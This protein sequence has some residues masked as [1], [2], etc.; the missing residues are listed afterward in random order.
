MERQRRCCV[1]PCQHIS[2]VDHHFFPLIKG[3]AQSLFSFPF[4]FFFILSRNYKKTLTLFLFTQL[5]PPPVKT[6]A[7]YPSWARNPLPPP[8]TLSRTVPADATP[9]AIRKPAACKSSSFPLI[10]HLSGRKD[11][12]LLLPLVV[13][14]L[15]VYVCFL[16]LFHSLPLAGAFISPSSL[17]HVQQGNGILFCSA[18]VYLIFSRFSFLL[19][20]GVFAFYGYTI[21]LPFLSFV[22]FTITV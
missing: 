9:W 3:R 18:A 21:V 14:Y 13:C 20:N 5:L 8:S 2:F 15:C 22:H 6:T 16:F 12:L 1:L 4:F 11:I 17:G 7:S 10:L 19:W